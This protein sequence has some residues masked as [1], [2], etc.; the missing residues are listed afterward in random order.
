MTDIVELVPAGP[1]SEMLDEAF[2]EAGEYNDGT[3]I[4]K[5][6]TYFSPTAYK[7]LARGIAIVHW[8]HDAGHEEK[9]SFEVNAG[10]QKDEV[11]VFNPLE[12]SINFD[13]GEDDD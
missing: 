7:E 8:D 9:F 2:L 1:L 6:E 3:T 12:V 13:Q 11:M 4:I 10:T 5:G